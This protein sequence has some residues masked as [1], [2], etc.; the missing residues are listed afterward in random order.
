MTAG[1]APFY[2]FDQYLKVPYGGAG[3]GQGGKAHAP[4]E[5]A[6]VKGMKDLEKSVV[7]TLWKYAEFAGKRMRK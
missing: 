4:N 5:Y 2:L 3:L 7:T 1:S 6:V